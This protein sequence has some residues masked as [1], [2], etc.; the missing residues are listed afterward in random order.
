MSM[1]KVIGIMIIYFIILS[2]ISKHSNLYL[3]VFLDDE[4]SEGSAYENHVEEQIQLTSTPSVNNLCDMS[5]MNDSSPLHQRL[6][7]PQTSTSLFV[8]SYVSVL[9]FYI[10]IKIIHK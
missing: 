5:E 9:L 10:N 1:S 8:N 2:D 3:F 7:G 6:S 4:K